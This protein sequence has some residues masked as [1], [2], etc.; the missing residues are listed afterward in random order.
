MMFVSSSTIAGKRIVMDNAVEIL[1]Y[2]T[3]MAVE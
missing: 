2:G 1:V 3:A